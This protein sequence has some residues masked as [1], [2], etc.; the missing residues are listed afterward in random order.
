MGGREG[1]GGGWGFVGGALECKLDSSPG[2]S[3]GSSSVGVAS[4]SEGKSALESWA[5]TVFGGIAK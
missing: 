3:E 5:V 4:G 1:R 2:S